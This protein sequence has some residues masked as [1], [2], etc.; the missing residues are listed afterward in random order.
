[1]VKVPPEQVERQWDTIQEMAL[2]N[3]F[4]MYLDWFGRRPTLDK[5]VERIG[6]RLI[7]VLGRKSD[8]A[9]CSRVDTRR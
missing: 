3:D 2:S 4:P 6:S 5:R 9:R 7:N 8:L 1:M